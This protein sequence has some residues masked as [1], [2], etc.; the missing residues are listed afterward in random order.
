MFLYLQCAVITE[1][2]VVFVDPPHWASNV[3]SDSSCN[4]DNDKVLF[5]LQFSGALQ[6]VL[7]WKSIEGEDI[8]HHNGKVY[9]PP[10]IR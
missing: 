2:M 5:P 7:L 6:P 8:I 9:I 3:V 10:A 4:V 1:N